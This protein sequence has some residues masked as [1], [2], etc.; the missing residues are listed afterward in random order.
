[1]DG[2]DV[3]TVVLPE[4][5]FKFFVTASPEQRA[6]RGVAAARDRGLSIAYE[7]MLREMERR[8]HADITRS[9]APLKAAPDA[10]VVDTT[11]GPFESICSRLVSYIRRVTETR[12]GDEAVECFS[13]PAVSFEAPP[14]EPVQTEVTGAS[15]GTSRA[16]RGE[17]TEESVI[18]LLA[19]GSS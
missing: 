9:L 12:F 6:L 3:G 7:E 4:A 17:R 2:R 15:N 11:V 8:D 5:D 1:M 16:S 10:I 14:H 18:D 13:S 19:G